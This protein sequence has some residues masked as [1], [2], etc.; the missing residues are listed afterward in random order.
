MSFTYQ[1]AYVTFQKNTTL[2]LSIMMFFCS[3]FSVFFLRNE[4]GVFRLSLDVLFFISVNA[5]F[6][7]SLKS[8]ISHSSLSKRNVFKELAELS[9]VS[10]SNIFIFAGIYSYFGI[11]NGGVIVQDIYDCL[12]FSIVTWTTLGYGD[13]VPSKD[14]QFFAAGEAMIGYIYM[15]IIISI[16]TS[17]ITR[18]NS[19]Q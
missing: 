1:K 9:C 11:S 10:L 13:F 5:C 2:V 7:V 6:V 3:A 18:D 15:A 14:A 17:A 16:F 12:Y 8:F 4:P 19:S